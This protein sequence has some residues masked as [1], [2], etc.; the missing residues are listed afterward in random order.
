MSTYLNEN[1]EKPLKIF[2]GDDG[3]YHYI[4]KTINK[5]NGKYY[6]GIHSTDN[7]DDGYLGSGT[8]LKR[9][10]KKYG[11][12]NFSHIILEFFNS[13]QELSK[14]EM[15]MVDNVVV[16]DP[17]SYNS[18]LGGDSVIE[19]RRTNGMVTV[20]NDNG[21]TCLMSKYDPRYISGEYK[22][23]RSGRSVYID[24]DGNRVDAATDDPRVLSG[25]LTHL[26]KGKVTLWDTENN[27]FICVNKEDPDVIDKRNRGIYVQNFTNLEGRKY[28]RWL[29]KDGEVISVH[30]SEVQKYLDEGWVVGNHHK[31]LKCITK[32]GVNTRVKDSELQKYLDEGWELGTN[33]QYNSGGTKFKGSTYVHKDGKTIRVF[34]EEVQKYLDEGWKR[35]MKS[36]YKTKRLQQLYDEENKE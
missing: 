30:V 13:R 27:K 7:V 22:F 15:D 20:K 11:K 3:L 9:A 21:E 12:E 4:Y 36:E 14:A 19:M 17:N 31:G 28:L 18:V 29:K 24:K 34:P 8:V 33:Q 1:L 5:I 2:R 26:F 6:I 16:M 32:D 23:I 35:G 25:E 10:I